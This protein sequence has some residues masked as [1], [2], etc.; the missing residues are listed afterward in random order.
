MPLTRIIKNDNFVK[1]GNRVEIVI[2]DELKKAIMSF[3]IN[4]AVR[5]CR[6]Y[7]RKPNSMLIHVDRRKD[8]HKRIY[9]KVREYYESLQE[10]LIDGDDEII[11]ELKQ[12]WDDD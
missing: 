6:G 4:I 2:T 12:I 11:E 7:N 1:N 10:M 9:P 8:S 5:N 3:I